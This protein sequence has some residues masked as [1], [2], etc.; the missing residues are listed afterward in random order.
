MLWQLR[1][2]SLS[3]KTLDGTQSCSWSTVFSTL[4]KRGASCCFTKG[5]FWWQKEA[6]QIF[7]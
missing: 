1:A 7:K 6:G 5:A 2:L 3:L 4:E